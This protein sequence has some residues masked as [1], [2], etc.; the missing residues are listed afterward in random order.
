[1]YGLSI[2]NILLWFKIITL[3]ILFYY[4]NN[5]KKNEF[6]Y[7]KNLGLTKQILWT[8]TLLFDILLFVFLMVL[9]NIFR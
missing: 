9:T 6:Y 7:Y 3:G 2:L 1:M 4:I 5:R 8:L